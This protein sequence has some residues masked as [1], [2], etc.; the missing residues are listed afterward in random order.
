MH[1]TASSSEFLQI[2]AQRTTADAVLT[3][4]IFDGKYPPSALIGVHFSRPDG[5]PGHESTAVDETF[6][7]R[8]GM[9]APHEEQFPALIESFLQNVHTKNPVLDADQLV[10]QARVVAS[11]GLRWDAWSC[12]VLLA[13]ALGRVA[14]PF[15]VTIALSTSPSSAEDV[16]RHAWPF[17]EAM[18]TDGLE[19]AESY[20]VLACRR[21]GGLKHSLLGSQCFFFAGGKL[22]YI[23]YVSRLDAD[24]AS[25]LDVHAAATAVLA[26]LCSSIHSVST[27]YEH[28]LSAWTFKQPTQD[29]EEVGGMH[30]MCSGVDIL[31]SVPGLC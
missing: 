25:L 18:T 29:D 11:D 6:T 17:E 26:I 16:L 28:G 19:E 14:K 9:L 5:V 3:W 27:V 2:P 23:S 7:V 12:L 22:L 1:T 20:F 10:R 31:V 15:D 4:E 21:L 30:G 24:C 13:A 8:Q